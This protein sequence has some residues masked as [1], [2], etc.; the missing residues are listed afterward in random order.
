MQRYAPTYIVN[1]SRLPK[2]DTDKC[3]CVCMQENLIFLIKNHDS[4]FVCYVMYVLYVMY[5]KARK[6]IC[7]RGPKNNHNSKGKCSCL[8]FSLCFKH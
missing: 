4:I 1:K 5:V 7:L 2:N 3:V 6:N 8:Y